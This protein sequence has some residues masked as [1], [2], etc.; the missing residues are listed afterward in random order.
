MFFL[1]TAQNV[2]DDNLIRLPVTTF[3]SLTPTY[4]Y[5]TNFHLMLLQALIHDIITL[6]LFSTW[7]CTGGVCVQDVLN[8]FIVWWSIKIPFIITCVKRCKALW[9]GKGNLRYQHRERKSEQQRNPF[10]INS[11]FLVLKN[12]ILSFLNFWIERR[13]KCLEARGVELSVV[14]QRLKKSGVDS[15][16]QSIY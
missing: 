10:F 13:E 12:I 7:F 3:M 9:L 14:K 15:I 1:S 8:L 11:N 4:I 6:Y 2:L 16:F 5:C